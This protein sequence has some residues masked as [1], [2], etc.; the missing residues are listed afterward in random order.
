MKRYWFALG[1]ALFFYAK[2]DILIWQRIFEAHDLVPLGIG[3]YHW[4]WLQSL[5]GFM[6]LGALGC[7]PNIRRM[8]LFPISLY[9][10]AYSG[11]EDILYYWLDGKSVPP[12][13]PWLNESPLVLKPATASTVFISAAFWLAIVFLLYVTGAYLE[14]QIR[15]IRTRNS[16]AMAAPNRSA[17]PPLGAPLLNNSWLVFQRWFSKVMGKI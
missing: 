11:I 6:I 3:V 15:K 9:L 13:L 16:Q 10:L 8:I 4:G 7:F 5:F 12:S 17:I 1:V 2:V 14:K